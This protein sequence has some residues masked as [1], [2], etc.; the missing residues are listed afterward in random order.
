M[1]APAIASRRN[2]SFIAAGF[3][4]VELLVVL[5][6]I[7]IT[8]SIAIP[9]FNR[10][11]SNAR[12][13]AETNKLVEAIRMARSKAVSSHFNVIVAPATAGN[14][15]GGIRVFMDMDG[16]QVMDSGEE[17][18]SYGPPVASITVSSTFDNRITYRPDGRAQAG[19]IFICADSNNPDYRRIVI[20]LAGRIQT[21]RLADDTNPLPVARCPWS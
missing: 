19:S 8:A 17:L 13:V 10:F 12:L 21:V 15:N 16:N 18:Q 20:A 1:Q 3:T 5:A 2:P 6:I 9:S 11:V 7:A 14:W 4:L